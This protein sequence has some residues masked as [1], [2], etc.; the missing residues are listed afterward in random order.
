MKQKYAY[1]KEFYESVDLRATET[2]EIVFKVVNSFIEVRSIVDAGCGSGAWVRSSIK[3]GA[4]KAYGVDLG[5]SLALI[6]KN[7]SF[8]EILA[9]GRLVLIERDFVHNPDADIPSADLAI[10]LEVV[11]HLPEDVAKSLVHRLTE[12][13]NFIV[14]SAAQPG[15]GGTY[16]INERPI[17]YWVKEFAKYE[18]EPYDPFRETLMKNP[19]IP[20][21]YSLNMLLFVAKG[22]EN[23][24][25]K[26]KN[27]SG[28]WNT[29]ITNL[30]KLEKRSFLEILRYSLIRLLPVCAVTFLSKRLKY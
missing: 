17:Q 5:S 20:R 24:E 28:L 22:A 11:E 15:Q 13:S 7:E 10:C 8:R 2:A 14:F 18:V 29:K 3:E 26:I 12:A 23:F 4:K 30:K 25:V 16:H 21:F 9:D 1:T 27:H 6:K 19:R